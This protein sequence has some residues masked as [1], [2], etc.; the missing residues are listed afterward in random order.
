MAPRR[1]MVQPQPPARE[2]VGT[3]DVTRDPVSTRPGGW[4]SPRDGVLPGT[5]AHPGG[6]TRSLSSSAPTT[7]GAVYV[8]NSFGSLAAELT[9]EAPS[10]PRGS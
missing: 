6:H 7:T 3:G 5:Q 2:R 9:L 4:L 8:L 1:V 10:E